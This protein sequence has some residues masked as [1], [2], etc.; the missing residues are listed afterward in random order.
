MNEDRGTS[1]TSAYQERQ[2]KT[3]PDQVKM[4]MAEHLEEN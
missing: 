2:M 1:G 4:G 3:P